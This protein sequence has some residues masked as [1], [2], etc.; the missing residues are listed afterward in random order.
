[1]K[2]FISGIFGA[3]NRSGCPKRG[4]GRDEKA[5]S[6]R[7]N[8]SKEPQWRLKGN[9]FVALSASQYSG[10]TSN[11]LPIRL[12]SG[13]GFLESA[14]RK[15]YLRSGNDRSSRR[16]VCCEEPAS[17]CSEN[18]P[19]CPAGFP[20]KLTHQAS[21]QR[22]IGRRGATNVNKSR[23]TSIGRSSLLSSWRR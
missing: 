14:G 18:P 15:P 19:S 22:E 5:Q 1:M 10:T 12:Q 16:N 2:R 13:S 9:E 23:K 3:V 21:V 8:S 6:Q 4:N 7:N 11:S 20:C 17:R